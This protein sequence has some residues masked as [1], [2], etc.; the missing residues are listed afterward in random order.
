MARPK[1]PKK[2]KP[3]MD[4]VNV[5]FESMFQEVEQLEPTPKC[6]KNLFKLAGIGL[7]ESMIANYYG[8]GLTKFK[9]FTTRDYPQMK[10]AMLM[11]KAKIGS[12]IAATL[13]QMALSGDKVSMIFYL[14]A[15]MGWRDHEKI[16]HEHGLGGSLE[17][18][19]KKSIANHNNKRQEEVKKIVVPK[20]LEG[21]DVL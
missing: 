3:N 19:I 5:D 20:E 11:G 2:E 6:L 7:P 17:E 21:A 1:K 15:Q 18:A 4:D 13:A 9:E 10:K 14:K 8:V 12:R 16:Q